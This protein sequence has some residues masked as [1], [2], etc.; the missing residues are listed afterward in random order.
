MLSLKNASPIHFIK[1]KKSGNHPSFI[2][3][4]CLIIS[5][6]YLF[7]ILHKFLCGFFH[8]FHNFTR[9]S[10]LNIFA[11]TEDP[12]KELRTD[13]NI[14][15]NLTVLIIHFSDADVL[16][17]SINKDTTH[18]GLANTIFTKVFFP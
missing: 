5:I 11:Q 13:I 6:Q 7:Q 17:K 12:S 2:C 16:T 15:I 4:N 9:S 10:N 1:N 18:I 8:F 3:S 14:H